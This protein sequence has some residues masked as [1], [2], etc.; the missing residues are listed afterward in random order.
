LKSLNIETLGISRTA[1]YVN[2]QLSTEFQCDILDKSKLNYIISEFKPD[3]IYHLAGPAFIPES[4]HE[5]SK[6]YEVIFNGTL[7]LLTS[8]RES[9]L[10]CKILYVSSA[11]VYGRNSSEILSEYEPCDPINPYA[12]AKSCAELLCKQFQQTYGMKVVIA[13]PFNHTGAGQSHSF[14]CSN[15]AK[16]IVT[17]MQSGYTD[18]KLFVGNIDVKRDFLDVRDVVDAY[19]DLLNVGLSGEIYNVCSGKAVSVRQIIEWL[20]EFTG[21]GDCEIIV[22][23]SKVRE[24][25]IVVRIGNN[26]KLKELTGWT[27]NYDLKDTLKDLISYW[28]EHSHVSG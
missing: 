13:R 2:G 11:D 7:N 6:T 27:P 9:G 23:P 15:F 21:I 17:V 26:E 10:D 18:A 3:H 20:L 28:K 16:Q 8:V 22:D 5:P 14:V 4:F 24:N 19:N 1:G 25:D 12:S